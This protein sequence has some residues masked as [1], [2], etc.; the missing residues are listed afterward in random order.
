MMSMGKFI[1]KGFVYAGLLA[2]ASCSAGNMGLPPDAEVLGEDSIRVSVV[3][4]MSHMKTRSVVDE[5]LVE[6]MNLYLFN[7]W[8]DLAF[9]GYYEDM[10]NVQ[11][12]LCCSGIYMAYVLANAGESIYAKDEEEVSEV[13]LSIASADDIVTP[14]G[15]LLM[16]GKSSPQVLEGGD[17]IEVPLVRCVSKI[18][19]QCNFEALNPDVEIGIRSI[20]LKNIPKRVLP[21]GENRITDAALSIDGMSVESPDTDMLEEGVSFYQYENMQ[22]TLNPDNL[23]Q[24]GKVVPEGSIYRSICSYIEMD[25]AYSSPRKRG[26]ILYRFYLGNDMTSNYDVV[27]NTQ[28]SIVVRFN[29]DG[30]VN[31]NT[32]RVDCG[33]IVDLVSSVTLDRSTYTFD[34]WGE[35]MQLQATV[36]PATANDRGLQ[37]KSSD[38]SVATVDGNGLVTS[39]N[40]GCCTITATSVDGTGI[41]A[42]CDIVVDAWIPVTGLSLSTS[43]EKMYKGLKVALAATV[44]PEDATNKG[45]VWRSTNDAVATVDANGNVTGGSTLG[46]CFIIAASEENATIS[47]SCQVDLCKQEYVS[48]P[49]DRNITIKVGESRQLEWSTIPKDAKPSFK[50]LNPPALTVTEDGVITGIRPTSAIVFIRVFGNEDHYFVTVEE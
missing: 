25:A 10:G 12:S 33:N 16:A 15:G 31:E 49:G 19:L 36:L 24:S 21:F 37:W 40:D 7:E 47:D 23:E 28:Y 17:R 45:V 46:T 14:R 8:G 20:R 41:S 1:L 13:L 2:L 27:R 18:S 5:N 9:Y 26:D 44:T 11:A 48:I 4:N 39:V 29:G 3:C 43:Y 30:G 32:W 42:S 35:T 34:K 38:E 6:D 50:S 22:G